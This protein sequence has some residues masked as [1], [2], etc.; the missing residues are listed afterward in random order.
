MAPEWLLRPLRARIRA[1]TWWIKL[2]KTDHAIWYD[3]PENTEAICDIVGHIGQIAALWNM[4]GGRD[5][6]KTE[7][8]VDWDKEKKQVTWTPWIARA[9]G[10]I[11]VPIQFMVTVTGAGLPFVGGGFHFAL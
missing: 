2:V 1:R 3:P 4:D 5:P 9:P 6:E 8:T 11:K 10:P 7:L